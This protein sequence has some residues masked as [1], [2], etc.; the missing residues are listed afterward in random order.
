MYMM[1]IAF[2]LISAIIILLC[3]CSSNNS[4]LL[5]QSSA[6]VS[7]DPFPDQTSAKVSPCDAIKIARTQVPQR[8]A[9]DMPIYGFRA[10]LGTYGT[11]FLTF[12]NVDVTFNE[13]GWKGNAGD[14]YKIIDSHQDKPDGVY[15]NIVIYVDAETG[16]V[17]NRE[18]NNGYFLGPTQD[19][20]CE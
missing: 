13:L 18:I 5:D 4:Q 2:L 19:L 14:Y 11:W 8:L 20:H 7:A 3:G 1:K 9:G 16:K 6:N 10:E 17:T 12:A 15:A